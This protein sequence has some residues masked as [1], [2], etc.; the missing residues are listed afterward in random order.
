MKAVD[1]KMSKRVRILEEYTG[2]KHTA[3]DLLIISPDA[4]VYGNYRNCTTRI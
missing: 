1:E 3:T 4:A 2:K